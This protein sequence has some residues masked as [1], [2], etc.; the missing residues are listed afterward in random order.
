M[1]IVN[2]F[3][4]WKKYRLDKKSAE[5]KLMRLDEKAKIIEQKHI[6]K[7]KAA[8]DAY[9]HYSKNNDAPEKMLEDFKKELGN[10]YGFFDSFEDAKAKYSQMV[11]IAKY[12]DSRHSLVVLEAARLNDEYTFIRERAI[13]HVSELKKI[14]SK[15]SVKDRKLL[16]AAQEAG[17]RKT[18]AGIDGNLLSAID[19]HIA[20]GDEAR[21]NSLRQSGADSIDF[22]LGSLKDQSERVRKQKARGKYTDEDRENERSVV[23]QNLAIGAA[24]FA[25][26]GIANIIGGIMEKNKAKQAMKSEELRLVA[27]IDKIEANRLKAEAF[28]SRVGEINRSLN[29]SIKG[30][31]KIYEETVKILFPEGDES[32][33]HKAR[34]KRE[35]KGEL[36]F[37]ESEESDILKLCHAAIGMVSLVDAKL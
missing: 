36:Y 27:E 17:L 37:I 11:Y 2:I 18:N 3:L 24:G 34:R 14:T 33:T 28:C 31:S 25:V 30:Y 22:V 16:D 8:E 7:I 23:V 4:A 9:Q 26:T 10:G 5:K 20:E 13:I 15:L 19:A 21:W 29:K 35:K 6:A 32:K 12:F 1:G